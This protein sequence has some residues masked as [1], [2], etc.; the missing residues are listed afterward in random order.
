M[1]TRISRAGSRGSA[2]PA[3]KSRRR[4]Q[5][6]HTWAT[7][8]RA[9]R[10]EPPSPAGARDLG[11]AGL[12]YAGHRAR[13]TIGGLKLCH[14]EA[15][16]DRSESGSTR[17]CSPRSGARG[18]TRAARRRSRRESSTQRSAERGRPS[19]NAPRD[20][21]PGRSLLLRPCA[22]HAVGPEAP[23]AEVPQLRRSPGAGGLL[24]LTG[25]RSGPWF[26]RPVPSPQ[27]GRRIPAGWHQ[28]RHC[29][30]R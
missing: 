21:A 8:F 7:N 27:S 20:E 22:S 23:A 18:A 24:P 28:R 6:M 13:E 29:G 15:S 3:T 16:S 14:R 17:K 19:G 1:V 11:I 5:R 12:D 2:T 25:G 26:P 9:S 10:D 4:T 30:S